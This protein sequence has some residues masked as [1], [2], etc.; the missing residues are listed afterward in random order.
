MRKEILFFLLSIVSCFPCQDNEV[1]PL[2]R[3]VN[4]KGFSQIGQGFNATTGDFLYTSIFSDNDTT[5]FKTIATDLNNIEVYE[6]Y[7][8]ISR[9]INDTL[10]FYLNSNNFAFF[11]E[12]PFKKSHKK[13]IDLNNY[14]LDAS[15]FKVLNFNGHLGIFFIK[16]NKIF[17]LDLTNKNE[18][19]IAN[20]SY[21]GNK[22]SE[23]SD[24]D[25]KGNKVALCL[26]VLHDNTFHYEYFLYNLNN[27]DYVKIYEG[28]KVNHQ[29]HIPV[30]KFYDESTVYSSYYT[31]DSNCLVYKIKI[32][33]NEI[34]KINIGINHKIINISSSKVREKI[35]LT[36]LNENIRDSI[37][38][39]NK[40]KLDYFGKIYS[41][42]NI[43]EFQHLGD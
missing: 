42:I 29:T 18:V 7:N 1:N 17:F 9:F 16:E 14:D 25:L 43:Y 33:E 10:I 11:S 22:Y 24:F 8:H 41:G 23:I 6:N 36:I 15:N 39:K 19:I 4:L 21:F 2:S 40:N 34:N 13:L 27:K 38:A 20:I 37:I 3:K 5:K 35:Y 28:E 26:K 32:E 12:Y 31:S 30:V